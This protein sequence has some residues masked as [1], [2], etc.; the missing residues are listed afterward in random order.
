MPASI[1]P[2]RARVAFA[3]C[4]QGAPRHRPG[5]WAMFSFMAYGLDA[6]VL[7]LNRHYQPVRVTPAR[8]ALL[9]LFGG[10][11]RALDHKFEAHDFRAWMSTPAGQDDETIGT[12]SGPLRVPRVLL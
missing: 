4:A 10:A 9:L 3:R 8:R 11:A 12:T 1:G 6:P 2:A 5:R 7:V